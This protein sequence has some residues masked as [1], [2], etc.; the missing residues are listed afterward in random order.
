MN[1]ESRSNELGNRRDMELE[2]QMN[3]VKKSFAVASST[4]LAAASLLGFAGAAH[5]ALHATGTNVSSNGTVYFL[6]GSSKRPYTSA[7]AFLS[8]GFNSWG[9]VVSASAEDLALPTGAF[10]PPMD[11]SLINDMGTVYLITNG[12]RAGFTSAA[13]FL[14]LGYSFSNVIAGDTSFLTSAP[15]ISSTSMAHPAGTLVNQAGTVYLV[16]STGKQGIPSLAVFNSWGYSFNDVVP[17]NQYDDA[18]SMSAGIMPAFSAGCLSPLSCTGSGTV[19]PTPPV[20]TGNVSA[21]LASTSPS[22]ESLVAGESAAPIE[23]FNFSGTGTVTQVTLLKTGVSSSSSVPNVY[24]Y[25]G[26]QRL[27]DAASVAGNTGLVT[28]SNPNGLFTVSNGTATITVAADIATGISG[29]TVGFNLVSAATGSTAVAGTSVTGGVSGSIALV[30][31]LAKV[32]VT[33]ATTTPATGTI[34]PSTGVVV[35]QNTVSV[36]GHTVNFTRFALREI[37]SVNYTDINNYKLLVDGTQVAATQSLDSN[38]YVT[39]TLPSGDVLTTGSHTFAVLA[40]IVGGA[41]RTYSFSLQNQADIGLTDTQYGVGVGFLPYTATSFSPI[42]SG[43]ESV[44]SGTVVVQ[45]DNASPS[46]NT[47]YNGSSVNLAT[48]DLTAY[49]EA[50]KINTINVA[51]TATTSNGTTP[52]ATTDYLNNGKVVINGAQYGSTTNLLVGGNT[53]FTLNYTIQ[54]GTAVTLQIQADTQDTLSNLTTGL[55]PGSVITAGLSGVTNNAQGQTSLMVSTVPAATTTGNNIILTSGSLSGAKNATYQNQTVTAPQTGVHLGSFTITN[56]SQTDVDDINTLAL[57]FTGSTNFPASALNNVKVLINNTQAGTTYPTVSTMT[58]GSESVSVSPA[59]ALAAGSS[60]TVDVYGD[61]NGTVVNAGTMAVSLVASGTTASGTAITTATLTGQT[62][63]I[64]SGSLAAV[65]DYGYSPLAKIVNAPQTGVLVGA[66]KFTTTNSAYTINQVTLSFPTAASSIV[67]AVHLQTTSGTAVGTAQPLSGTSVTFNGLSFAVP[68]NSNG[69]TLEVLVDLGNIGPS[70]GTSGSQI[71]PTLTGYQTL[72]ANGVQSTITGQTL[73]TNALYAYS[74]IPSITAGNLPSSVLA[75]GTQTLAAFTVSSTGGTTAWAKI[76]FQVTIS[77]AA[78]NIVSGSF[79]LYDSTNTAIPGTFNPIVLAA[80]S[81]ST[82][83]TFT[84][85]N[86][87]EINASKSYTLKAQIAG[88]I[89]TGDSVSTAINHSAVTYVA[90][91]TEATVAGTAATFVWSD[92]SA[93]SHS[94]TTT[95]WN[96]DYLVTQLPVGSFTLSK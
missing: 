24:L 14:G 40:D 87:Q 66:Y 7:G 86:P 25:S 35:W 49:G 60:A 57:T 91:N 19:N 63:T 83:V 88:A 79:A 72:N 48:F 8:Y 85:T 43:T 58:T 5:A 70:S 12:Q 1:N 96:N 21:S 75:A 50:V 28:F 77:G 39:F 42:S 64:G 61:I 30:T 23:M 51:T 2:L 13:N 76:G 17:A 89:A 29:Q 82:L 6:D 95:D 36:S 71:T 45:K 55:A 47:T 22:G 10:V 74:A 44:Q 15:L 38:G 27:T 41:S 67:T 52:I 11:G 33:S 62:L 78:E 69:T 68:A 20:Q 46:G 93:S 56:G 94:L 31:D 90:P 16:T 4:A 26:S 84:P 73:V 92:E 9:T 18:L 81:G 54:P 37:G 59:L 3:I 32:Q 34:N 65:V 80:G 53:T